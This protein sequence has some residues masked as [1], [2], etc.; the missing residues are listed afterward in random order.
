MPL[1]YAQPLYAVFN[2]RN[3]SI[4]FIEERNQLQCLHACRLQQDLQDRHWIFTALN[5]AH[6][7][8][9]WIRAMSLLGFVFGTCC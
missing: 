1:R 8:Y 3:K 4:A 5:P 2:T 6:D 9:T 7:Q